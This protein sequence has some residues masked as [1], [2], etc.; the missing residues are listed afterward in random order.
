MK[1]VVIIYGGK[2]YEHDISIKSFNSFYKNVTPDKYEL[3][4][5]YVDKLGCW[6]NDDKKIDNIFGFLKSFDCVIPL[7]HG[8][9]GE[10]GRMQGLLDM[11]GVKYVGCNLISS[12]LCM[13]KAFCKIVIDNA[14]INQIPYIIVNKKTKMKDIL[15][16]LDFPMIIKPSN[17]GSSIGISVVNGKLELVK[18]LREAF[19]YDKKIVIEKFI[20]CRE[21]EVGILE[22]NGLVC[23]SIGEIKSNGFYD[24]DCKYVKNTDVVV[25]ANIPNHVKKEIKDIARR[26]FVN[27]ECKGFARV[28]FL[29]DEDDKKLYFNEINTIPGFTEISMFPKLFMHD[30]YSYSKLVDVLIKNAK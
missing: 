19:K 21:L 25:G 17:G 30:G 1:K 2:S 12:A 29:Y 9:Y 13:D 11:V 22:D 4:T 6:W 14:G 28:D 18:A 27:L 3:S 5:I 16:N 15:K 23:S 7:M 24:F 8:A 20:K 26:V 10:D